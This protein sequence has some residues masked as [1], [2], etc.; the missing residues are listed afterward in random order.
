M[1]WIP[2]PII[3]EICNI[4]T[5]AD[6]R[7]RKDFT[8]GLVV[9]ERDY[10][11]RFLT[12]TSYPRIT[13]GGKYNGLYAVSC[14]TDTTERKH[15]IDAVF[16]FK[17]KKG[18]K[19]GVCECKIEKEK[20]DNGR[21]TKQLAKQAD[22]VKKQPEIVVFEMFFHKEFRDPFEPD[23]STICT[24]HQINNFIEEKRGGKKP[25]V[26]K[27]KDLEDLFNHLKSKTPGKYSIDSLLDAILNCE[28][29]EF[30]QDMSS[31]Y[32][33][34]SQNSFVDDTINLAR[35]IIN[36]DVSDLPL[37]S[38]RNTYGIDAISIID[39]EAILRYQ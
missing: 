19:I 17:Y 29:G 31:N 12:L 4:F 2:I 10:V 34:N 27:L 20:F 1:P 15:G 3:A 36:N 6:S 8:K 32:S 35:S 9:N 18:I 39:F 22:L 21:F 23:L 5:D 33:Q 37:E 7:T 24:L 25:K 28:Q 11:S 16:V 14:S 13:G 30:L 38:Y 26:W